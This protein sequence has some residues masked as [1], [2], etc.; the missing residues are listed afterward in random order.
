[1]RTNSGSGRAKNN[2]GN[3]TLEEHKQ[4]RGK[5]GEA[6][7][8]AKQVRAQPSRTRARDESHRR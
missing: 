1:M 4:A 8:G 3:P 5:S 7:T 6:I 2:R